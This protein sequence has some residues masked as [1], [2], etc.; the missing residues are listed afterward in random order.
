MSDHTEQVEDEL[1]IKQEAFDKQYETVK[2]LLENVQRKNVRVA[3]AQ[4]GLSLSCLLFTCLLLH[5]SFYMLAFT[6]LLAGRRSK[7]TASSRW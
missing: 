1:R 4:S 3:S 7:S 2:M 5:A 6:C